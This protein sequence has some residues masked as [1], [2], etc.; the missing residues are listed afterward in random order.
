MRNNWALIRSGKGKPVSKDDLS[1][2]A[3]LSDDF[4]VCDSGTAGVDFTREVRD[5]TKPKLEYTRF[6]QD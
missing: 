2:Q 6:S 4:G 1:K 5:I 3:C